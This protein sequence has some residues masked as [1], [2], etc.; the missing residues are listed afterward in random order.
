MHGCAI[1]G[2]LPPCA[3]EAVQVVVDVSA[4]W[5]VVGAIVGAG[6]AGL[7]SWMTMRRQERVESERR[8][9]DR[10]ER[11]AERWLEQRKSVYLK[12]MHSRMEWID[13]TK[14]LSFRPGEQTR[15][16]LREFVLGAHVR[17][18]DEIALVGTAEAQAA[19]TAHDHALAACTGI[20]EEFGQVERHSDDWHRLWEKQRAAN[21]EEGKV[22][23]RRVVPA[24]R[25]DLD[26]DAM[27]FSQ[28]RV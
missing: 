12:Y 11:A 27:R 18:I 23:F 16:A 15:V 8:Q 20:A 17:L 22:Y 26:M 5:T 4:L 14:A 21:R 3:D 6:T 10:R 19:V 9:E 28:L 2:T 13:H 1:S 7:V 24:F 25:A